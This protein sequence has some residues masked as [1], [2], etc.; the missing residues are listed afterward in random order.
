M[1]S[2]ALLQ[3]HRGRCFSP[4]PARGVH[5]RFSLVPRT[6][7]GSFQKHRRTQNHHLGGK[8]EEGK[9]FSSPAAMRWCRMF[10]SPLAIE[11]NAFNLAAC[12]RVRGEGNI[13]WP[14]SSSFFPRSQRVRKKLTRAREVH[15][16]PGHVDAAGREKEIFLVLKREMKMCFHPGIFG[17]PPR[18][19]REGKTRLDR[20]T[21]EKGSSNNYI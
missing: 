19:E 11:L 3:Y 21:R 20:C 10:F 5:F 6:S 1:R 9:V 18:G 12:E 8:E 4:L 15:L 2:S 17:H 16:I 13:S 7:Q 14:I